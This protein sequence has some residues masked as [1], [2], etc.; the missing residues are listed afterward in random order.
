MSWLVLIL[1]GICES[2]WAIALDRSEGFSRIIPTVVFAIG[3]AAS[4]GGLAFAMKH[5]PI[6]TS[7]AI[8]VGIGAA[9]TAVYGM[10][11]GEETVSLMRVLLIG[12]LVAC[13]IGLKLID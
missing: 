9:I 2:V 10:V 3:L 8:W 6:G 11:S 5:V 1:S 12:G 13:V 7:Y 4:M